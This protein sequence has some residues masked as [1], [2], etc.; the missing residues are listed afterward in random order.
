MCRDTAAGGRIVEVRPQQRGLV[1]PHKGRDA[2]QA[3]VR[4]AAQGIQIGPCIQ[5]LTADLLR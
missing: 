1:I 3:L 5:R 4:N 2:G